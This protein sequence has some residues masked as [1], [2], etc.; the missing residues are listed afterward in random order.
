MSVDEIIGQI[1]DKIDK[2]FTL[3]FIQLQEGSDLVAGIT[4]LLLGLVIIL[5]LLLTPLVIAAELMYI[6]I[7][8]FRQAADN[9]REGKKGERKLVG[10][11]LRDAELALRRANTTVTGKSATLIYIG[12]KSKSVFIVTLIVVI[13]ITGGGSLID[14]VS[15]LVSGITRGFTASLS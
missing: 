2:P 9:I 13:L 15:G 10:L 11:A 14:F 7:P 12:I 4:T 1:G 6:N 3:N 5:I 8:I